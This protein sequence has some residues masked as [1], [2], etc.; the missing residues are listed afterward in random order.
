MKN[1]F[2]I[3][4]T[5][6]ITIPDDKK[7]AV[8]TA[9]RENYKTVAEVEKIEGK[10]DLYK[11]QLDTAQEA[12]KG[13]DGINVTEL[14]GK[15]STLT[16]ELG[17]KETEYNSKLADMGFNSSL[18]KAIASSGARDSVAVKAHLK[19]ESLKSS[20][21]QSEDIKSAIE[22]V[23]AEKDYLFTSDKPSVRLSGS[24]STSGDS[25]GATS[26]TSKANDA[27]RSL[28]GKE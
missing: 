16:A 3:L 10:R 19:L 22:A 4:S 20:K 9:V 7:T 8:E 23:K 14:N 17:K 18:E 24:V 27:L 26:Q 21:N 28:F 11:S 1:I 5:N 13:F 15:I 25:I 12:L 6:G 2:E